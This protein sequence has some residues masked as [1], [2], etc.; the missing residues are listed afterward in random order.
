MI[1]QEGIVQ[2]WNYSYTRSLGH[3]LLAPVKGWEALQALL[4]TFSMD[5]TESYTIWIG[6]LQLIDPQIPMIRGLLFGPS[7]GSI[8]WTSGG[9]SDQHY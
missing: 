1:I 4:G 9:G 6:M 5:Y 3:S 7:L 8:V 2:L